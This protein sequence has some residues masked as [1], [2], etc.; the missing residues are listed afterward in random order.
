[1]NTKGVIFN[2]VMQEKGIFI[3]PDE[4]E[5]D[6]HI[7]RKLAGELPIMETPKKFPRDFGYWSD[8]FEKSQE[9]YK[10]TSDIE[11]DHV[12]IQ[13]KGDTIINF[14]GDCHVG[15][16]TTHYDRLRQEIEAIVDTPNSYVILVGDLVDG[17]FFNPA[18]MEEVAQAPE[19][20]LYMHALIDHLVK[21]KKLL[22]AFSGQHDG[23]ARKMGMDPYEVFNKLGAYYMQGVGHLTAKVDDQEYKFVGA[24][25]LPGFSMY[26]NTHPQMRASKEIQGAD[27]YFGADTHVKGHAE[28]PIKEFGGEA[29]RVS[30]ISIGSYKPTDEFARKLGYGQMAPEEMYGCSVKLS[31]ENKIVTY[32]DNIL[33]ANG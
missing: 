3:S 8:R 30:F 18:Q 14:I 16:T 15:A 6:K 13:F 4:F 21:N 22:M 26:N 23:W 24:H 31:S 2:C 7:K 25:K 5:S 28:Q 27:I 33:E 17:F 9:L 20:F 19:Q 32:Y 1:M 11:T 12:S 10:E 29:R